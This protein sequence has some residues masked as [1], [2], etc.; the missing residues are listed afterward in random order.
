MNAPTWLAVF[1]NPVTAPA[2]LRPMSRHTPNTP[3]CWNETAL[4]TSASRIRVIICCRVT[5]AAMVNSP[6]TASAL[7]PR[8][9]LPFVRPRRRTSA[10]LTAPPDRF[11]PPASTKGSAESS[12]PLSLNPRPLYQET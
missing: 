5:I 7:T 3:A 6:A 9:R 11:A 2:W 10:S 4:Y 12:R 1:I 8:T